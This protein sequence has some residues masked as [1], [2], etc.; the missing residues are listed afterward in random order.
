MKQGNVLFGGQN[1]VLLNKSKKAAWQS[2]FFFCAMKLKNKIGPHYSP[3]RQ[4]IL[5]LI[6]KPSSYF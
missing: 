4:S 6:R 2:K 5:I 1:I 3:I